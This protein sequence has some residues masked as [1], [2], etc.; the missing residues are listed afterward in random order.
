M[1]VWVFSKEG[2]AKIWKINSGECNGIKSLS[3]VRDGTV[4]EN[5][6]DGDIEMIDAPS[7]PSMPGSLKPLM[8][9]FGGTSSFTSAVFAT[10]ATQR[11][12]VERSHQSVQYDSEGDVLMEDLSHSEDPS[13]EESQASFDQVAMAGLR[14]EIQYSSRSWTRRRDSGV[15]FIEELTGSARLNIEIR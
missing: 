2:I 11:H 8:E 13:D 1:I 6:D 7:S 14:G 4:R 10:R 3:V 5:D 9:S 15:D 12:Q